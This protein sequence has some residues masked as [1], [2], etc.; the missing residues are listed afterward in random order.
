[1]EPGPK[2]Y[3]SQNNFNQ[4]YFPSLITDL[5]GKI[6]NPSN[7]PLI[8]CTRGASLTDSASAGFIIALKTGSVAKKLK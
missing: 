2:I 3:S 4:P 1:M 7:A 8:I 5:K 6:A